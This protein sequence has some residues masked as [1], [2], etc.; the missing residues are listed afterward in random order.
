[1]VHT[2]LVGCMSGGPMPWEQQAQPTYAARP[3]PTPTTSPQATRAQQEQQATAILDRAQAVQTTADN[4]VALDG[5]PQANQVRQMIR[6]CRGDKNT[7]FQAVKNVEAQSK[8]GALAGLAGYLTQQVAPWVFSRS[9]GV[10]LP[11]NLQPILAVAPNLDLAEKAA[12][13]SMEEAQKVADAR[14]AQQ[15]QMDAEAQAISAATNDCAKSEPACKA[16]CDHDNDGNYCLAWAVRLRNSKTPKLTYARAYFQKACDAGNQH[17]CGSI[18]GVDQQI[19][20]AA[21]QV[22]GL[23][24]NVTDAGDDLAQKYHQVTMV[25]KMA[26][27]PRMQAAVQKMT[28]INQAIVTERYCPGKKAFIQGASAAEFQR[29]AV[30]HCKDQAPTGQGLSGAE[31][32]LTAECQQVYATQCP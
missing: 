27:T 32:T 9:E 23:W 11:L 12:N 10:N 16:K 24:G 20:N 17:G 14:D 4:A 13:K 19:Q 3:A 25:T 18:A 31:V 6:G 2:A 5:S 22:E 21:A 26:N 28:V 8:V 1:V 29:R 30:T 15:K 7:C